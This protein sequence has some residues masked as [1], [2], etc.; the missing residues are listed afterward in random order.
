MTG[1]SQ[2]QGAGKKGP[3]KLTPRKKMLAPLK[4]PG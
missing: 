2:Q 3:E 1:K 4:D